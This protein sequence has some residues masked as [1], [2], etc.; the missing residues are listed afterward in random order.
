MDFTV[1][2]TQVSPAEIDA[3]L[4]SGLY[5]RT[6]P[7]L[8][9]NLGALTLLS[10][11]LVNSAETP[12]ILLWACTL[13]GWTMLRFV[14]AKTYLSRP[15]DNSEARRWTYAFAVGS[16]VAGLLWGSS[17]FLVESLDPEKAR[18][19]TAFLMAALSA[20]AIAGYTNSMI[21]F[22][23][24]VLPSLLPFGIR[25]TW[26][27]GEFHA[28]IAAFVVFWAWLLWSMARHLNDGFKDSIGLV[29]HNQN[30]AK[31]L[32]RAK[33]VAEAA[34][35]AK[36]RFLANMSHELRT[37]LNAIVGYSEMMA[38]RMLGPLG[39]P[40]YEA[41]SRN[42]FDSGQHLLAMIEKVLDV[43]SIEAG[44]Y[45]LNEGL[46]D[47]EDLVESAVRHVRRA[48]SDDQIKLHIDVERNLPYLRG[49]ATKMRQ[50]LLNL[51]SNAVKFTPPKGHVMIAADRLADGGIALAIADTGVG[52]A[53]EDLV[54]VLTPFQQLEDQDHL[55]RS[56]AQ[57]GQGGHT[58]AGLGL[59]LAKLLTELHGGG[60]LLESRPN[61]GTTV[62]VTLPPERV[63]PRPKLPGGDAYRKAAE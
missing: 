25:L 21:A 29:L 36:T 40:T 9:A 11:S 14:L 57:D 7:L 63:T 51:L 48:A 10:L 61:F 33:D 42:I 17:L 62:T 43:S 3:V 35:L 8:I 26:L 59:P 44:K 31:R 5:R 53:Q 18:L 54:R 37:P 15:R 30:L 32:S 41:Y 56:R 13:A 28:L 38:N 45:H 60:L 2:R 27:D 24:F 12:H 4:I 46:I 22:M 52:I 55:K 19:V 50:I 16:G 34:S 58:N 23:A 47:V 49:D 1:S 20:A 39:N 6:K